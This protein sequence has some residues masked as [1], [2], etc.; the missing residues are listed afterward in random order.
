MNQRYLNAKTNLGRCG[1]L[2]FA[3]SLAT[4]RGFTLEELLVGGRR[5]SLAAARHEFWTVLRDS[6]TLSSVE[7]AT[8]TGHDHSTVLEGVKAHRER[9]E[10]H[11]GP[12]VPSAGVAA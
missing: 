9:L 10:K 8:L 11:Y 12:W 2:Q 1:L 3:E 4:R 6:T 5:P 7:I